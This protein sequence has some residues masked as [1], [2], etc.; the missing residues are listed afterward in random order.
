MKF[1][2]F[3]RSY[4]IYKKQGV[5]NH[6]FE[7]LR[8]FDVL[9]GGK[10]IE[11][12]SIQD[13]ETLDVAS[14]AKK[15]RQ[16]VPLEYILGKAPFMGKTFYCTNDTLIPRQ[17][18]SLLVTTAKDIISRRKKHG[19]GMQTV[20]EIGTGCGNIA[21]SLALLCDDGVRILASDISPSALKIA[22]RNVNKFHVHEKIMLFCGDL[23]EPFDDYQ[24]KTDMVICNPPYIPTT[25]LKKLDPEI[26]GHE[27]IVALDG[28]H[29]GIDF[30]RRLIN[31]AST[32]LKH[33]GVLIFE[34]GEGQ[35]KLVKRL[36]AG[37]DVYKNIEYYKYEDDIRVVSAI[38][39]K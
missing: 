26:I 4:A 37:K 3:L 7:T 8:L 23:F 21:V 39:E 22:R 2:D 30:F 28:G 38:K 11:A 15:R 12:L 9:S 17:E 24:G 13:L 34:I 19:S 33:G 29:Y 18:T 6:L 20:V 5:G 14:I 10:L 31:G 16:G 1:E 35:E 27:P 25:S 32:V 36:F